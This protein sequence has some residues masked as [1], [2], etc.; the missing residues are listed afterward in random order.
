MW[1]APTEPDL[2]TSHGNELPGS[3]CIMDA[4]GLSSKRY[5]ACQ[6]R[7]NLPHFSNGVVLLSGWEYIVRTRL[8]ILER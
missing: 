3:T 7:S 1:E 8:K 6:L 2:T 4:R 5:A